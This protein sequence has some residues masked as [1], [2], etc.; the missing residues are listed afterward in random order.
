MTL[1][2]SLTPYERSK[3]AVWEYPL[4]DKYI[5]IYSA[6]NYN[7][8]LKNVSQALAQLKEPKSRLALIAEASDIQYHAM[9]NCT[10]KEI[11]PEFSK[12]PYAIALQMNSP[13]TKEFNDV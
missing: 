12:K 2:D 13:L 1:N 8:L 7:T 10:F 11:G 4:S 9:L 3:L 6:I 5:K